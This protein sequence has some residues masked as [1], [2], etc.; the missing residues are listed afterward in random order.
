MWATRRNVSP[1]AEDEGATPTALPDIIADASGGTAQ[2]A[3][4]TFESTYRG[5]VPARRRKELLDGQAAKS[6]VGQKTPLRITLF[7]VGHDAVARVLVTLPGGCRST[8]GLRRLAG[9]LCGFGSPRQGT[10]VPDHS[11]QPR[12][13]AKGQLFEAPNSARAFALPP[14]LLGLTVPG[15]LARAVRRRGNT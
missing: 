7:S 11:G 10:D 14:I 9:R 2:G 4:A 15:Q 8:L 1:E 6:F 13:G 12:R 5:D 3:Q